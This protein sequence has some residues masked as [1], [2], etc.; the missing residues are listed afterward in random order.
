MNK[1]KLYD[2]ICS[3][4]TTYEDMEKEHTLML[5]EDFYNILVDVQRYFNHEIIGA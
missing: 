4:L 3:L 2:D 5:I 1:Q